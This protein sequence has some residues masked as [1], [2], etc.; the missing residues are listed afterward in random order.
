MWRERDCSLIEKKENKPQCVVKGKQRIFRGQLMWNTKQ[1]NNL[2]IF[3]SRFEAAAKTGPV[4][5]ESEI[6]LI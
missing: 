4:P 6:K 1:Q 3:L 5:E 2:L